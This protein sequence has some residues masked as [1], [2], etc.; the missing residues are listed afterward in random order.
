MTDQRRLLPGEPSSPEGST[1]EPR[2]LSFPLH[3]VLVDLPCY[4]SCL[5]N[6]SRF[7][8][9]FISNAKIPMNVIFL[10]EDRQSI[11]KVN[12]QQATTT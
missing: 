9:E 4:H 5:F 7:P 10:M 11:T 2:V 12:Q 8:M 1:V 3:T 6:F